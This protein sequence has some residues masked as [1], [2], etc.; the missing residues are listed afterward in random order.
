M[1]LYTTD[2]SFMG[3]GKNLSTKINTD[4]FITYKWKYI[5]ST[6]FLKYNLKSDFVKD[7]DYF[8]TLKIFKRRRRRRRKMMGIKVE[9]NGPDS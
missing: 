8:Y 9:L 3:G 4:S 2:F 6:L 7:R 1:L 5:Y